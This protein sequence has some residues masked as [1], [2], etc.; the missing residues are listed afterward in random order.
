MNIQE[1]TLDDYVLTNID[2]KTGCFT[3]RL[4]DDKEY[5]V[6][7]RVLE[8]GKVVNF[9]KKDDKKIPLSKEVAKLHLSEVRVYQREGI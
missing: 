5:I 8:T 4:K 1:I 3:I 6:Y 7:R 9:I 2:I